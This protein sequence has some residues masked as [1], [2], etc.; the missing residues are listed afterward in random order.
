MRIL[1]NSKFTISYLVLDVSNSKIMGRNGETTHFQKKKKKLIEAP[2]KELTS[3]NRFKD[4]YQHTSYLS[5]KFP[6][7]PKCHALP[8]L[9]QGRSSLLGYVLSP[10]SNGT[11]KQKKKSG[12]PIANPFNRNKVLPKVP[13]ML[14]GPIPTE[15]RS[16]PTI[17]N[18]HQMAIL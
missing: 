11:S 4:F 5:S 3:H 10:L 7:G 1:Q 8:V 2:P 17:V 12:P 18:T 16:Q 6:T 15:I 13:T 9:S 14:K